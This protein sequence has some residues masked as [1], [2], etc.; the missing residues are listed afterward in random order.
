MSVPDLAPDDDD[1][2]DDIVG[3]L[4]LCSVTYAIQ[5]V[6]FYSSIH[7]MKQADYQLLVIQGKYVFAFLLF[8]R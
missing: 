3:V 2:D 8:L 1:D 4:S 7:Y 6:T 5:F